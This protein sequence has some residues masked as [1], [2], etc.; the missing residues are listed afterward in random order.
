M[1]DVYNWSRTAG[2]S[3]HHPHSSTTK[4]C[5]CNMCGMQFN[6]FLLKYEMP[7]LK[8]MRAY[9]ALNLYIPFSTDGAFPDVPMCCQVHRH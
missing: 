7:S 5:C 1:P 2:R 3:F 8:E 9:V 4:V 6:I